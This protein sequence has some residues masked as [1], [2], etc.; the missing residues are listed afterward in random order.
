MVGEYRERLWGL[1]MCTLSLDSAVSWFFSGKQVSTIILQLIDMPAEET[2]CPFWRKLC[3]KGTVALSLRI[4]K[5]S[6]GVEQ[7]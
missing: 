2:G 5:V 1:G 4:H 3:V 7:E 6:L